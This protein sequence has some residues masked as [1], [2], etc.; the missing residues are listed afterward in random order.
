MNGMQTISISKLRQSVAD[1][2]D[3]VVA[4]QQPTIILNRSKPQA[5]LVDIDYYQALEEAV[6]DLTDAKEAERAKK[7][8]KDTLSSYI[9]KRWRTA[10]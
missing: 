8:P 5:V 7:E 3:M 4:K 10:V 1:I 2:L 9:K 6:L